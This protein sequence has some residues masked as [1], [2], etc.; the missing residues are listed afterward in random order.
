MLMGALENLQQDRLIAEQAGTDL[1][2][3]GNAMA[4]AVKCWS[5]RCDLKRRE[6]STEAPYSFV[7]IH[8][9][10]RYLSFER[11]AIVWRGN[12]VDDKT[13]AVT[14]IRYVRPWWSRILLFQ[15]WGQFTSY[16][17][18]AGAVLL[19]WYWV[20]HSAGEPFPYQVVVGGFLGAL[21]AVRITETCLFRVQRD[22]M[23]NIRHAIETRLE[24]AGFIVDGTGSV[25]HYRH[26][27]PRWLTFRENDVYL[28]P[29]NGVLVV[30]GPRYLIKVL[31]KAAM[32]ALPGG[33][34]AVRSRQE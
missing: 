34:A 3:Q 17:V 30:S 10:V 28:N 9:V 1:P 31:N 4:S 20:L 25:T 32:A 6:R 16:L 8:S 7:D 27:W 15:S 18:S 33:A 22:P 21:A 13:A 2:Y 29:G 24:R 23:G 12:S 14:P 11:A 26:R 19:L 5:R